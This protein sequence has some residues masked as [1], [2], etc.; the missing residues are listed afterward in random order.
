VAPNGEAYEM[1]PNSE[2]SAFYTVGQ[3]CEGPPGL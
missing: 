2:T 1:G 3:V